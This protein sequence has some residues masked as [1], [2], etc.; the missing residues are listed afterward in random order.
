MPVVNVQRGSTQQTTV[1]FDTGLSVQISIMNATQISWMVLNIKLLN[2]LSDDYSNKL[3]GLMGNLN[4]NKDDDIV[5]RIGI[6]PANISLESS[7]YPIANNCSLNFR[8]NFKI[9]FKKYL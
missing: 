8:K 4:G 5:S 1:L 6:K 7:I 9:T 2:G 3:V